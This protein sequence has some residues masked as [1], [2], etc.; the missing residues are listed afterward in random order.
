MSDIAKRLADY[1]ER[2]AADEAEERLHQSRVDWLASVGTD[3]EPVAYRKFREA[4]SGV[5]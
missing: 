1:L 2:E 3:E 5:R 4:L